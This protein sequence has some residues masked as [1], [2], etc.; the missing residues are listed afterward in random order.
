MAVSELGIASSKAAV[1]AAPEHPQTPPLLPGMEAEEHT[2]PEGF[3]DTRRS[4]RRAGWA[5]VLRKY[6][7]QGCRI[8]YDE[9]SAEAAAMMAEGPSQLTFR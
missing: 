9:A 8:E 2:V 1:L 6:P 4:S 3:T 5:P 7:Q